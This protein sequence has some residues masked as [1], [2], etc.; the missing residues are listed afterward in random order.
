MA[1]VIAFLKRQ[2]R[3]LTGKTLDDIL[4]TFKR[5]LRELQS[6][7]DK[8]YLE[9]ADNQEVIRGCHKRVQNLSVELSRA[10]AISKKLRDLI[11]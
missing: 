6:L 2:L 10:E 7:E 8:T 1:T 5:A 9:I 11:S 4:G 3:R